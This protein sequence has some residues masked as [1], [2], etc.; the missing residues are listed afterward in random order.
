M[1]LLVLGGT[2]FLGRHLVEAALARGDRVT[3]FHRG[4]TGAQLFPGAEHVL[5]DRDGG[6]AALAG[7]SFDAVVD[8]CGYFPRVVGASAA[9]LAGAAGHYTFVSSISAYASPLPAHAGEDAPLA[10]LADPATEDLAG[11]S[12]GGLKAACERAVAERFGA[13]ALIVRP[14]L[15]VGPSDPTE[16]FTYWPRRL[17]RGGD[18]LVPAAPELPVQVVDARDLAA[19][20]LAR[21]D[22]GDG[23]TYNAV[24]PAATLTLRACLERIAAA[25]G[26][27]PELVWVDEAFL[28]ARGVEPWTGLP[29]WVPPEE[30][31][32]SCVSAAR[33]IASGLALRPLEDTARDT[34]AWDRSRPEDQ[35]TNERL[36]TREREAELLAEWARR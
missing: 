26:A 13:P 27:R 33:A 1:N 22:A 18:V 6:L 5:G 34:L 25:I 3:L 32:F 36:L 7:R 23:G 31:T 24:G 2:R 11:G 8:T 10:T 15:I 35:R 20:M 9:A 4:R 19:W 28:L 29:L 30:A 12:Y 21:I 16:R 14:G 17:V